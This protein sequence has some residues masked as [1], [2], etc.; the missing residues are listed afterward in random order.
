VPPPSTALHGHICLPP[1]TYE[2]FVQVP[3][4]ERGATACADPAS[5]GRAK[6]Q[7][8]QPYHFITDINT[9]PGEEVLHIAI[10]QRE[11]GVDP[12]S[13]ANNVGVK[14]VTPI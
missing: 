8:S 13:V 12:H 1:D 2:N 3:D 14:A 6:F 7:N 9:A 4:L 11:A 10:A 5:I